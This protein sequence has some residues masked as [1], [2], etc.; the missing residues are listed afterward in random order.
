VKWEWKYRGSLIKEKRERE[1]N[2]ESETKKGIENK[3]D[4]N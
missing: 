3:W 1:I 4:A 2:G